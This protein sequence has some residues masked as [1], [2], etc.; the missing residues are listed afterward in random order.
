MSAPT[1]YPLNW[2]IGRPRTRPELQRDAQFR[3]STATAIKQI[4]YEV[5]RLTEAVFSEPIIS[6]NLPTRLDGFPYAGVRNPED[7]G[8]AVYFNLNGKPIALACDR[9]TK[10]EA[11]MTAI[12]RHLEAMRGQLRWG[13][14]SLEEAFAGYAALP[15]P[16]S[17]WRSVFGVKAYPISSIPTEARKVVLQ[18]VKDRFRELMKT[19]HPDVGGNHADAARLSAAL[20]AAEKELGG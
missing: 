3:T 5:Q 4:R 16:A 7:S 6:S 15:P 2:P 9:W 12:A 11:N 18:H 1:R 13:V 8:V 14:G 17:D 10:V 20:M 19:Q